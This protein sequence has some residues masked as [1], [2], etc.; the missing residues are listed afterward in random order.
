M[1]PQISTKQAIHGEVD[2][3]DLFDPQIDDAQHDQSH[4]LASFDEIFWTYVTPQ[5]HVWKYNPN[6]R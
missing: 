2:G 4:V 5:K 1:D 6:T 3:F